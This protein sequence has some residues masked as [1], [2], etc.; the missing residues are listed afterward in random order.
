M[1]IYFSLLFPLFCQ[2]SDPRPY[3]LPRCS[4]CEEERSRQKAEQKWEGQESLSDCQRLRAQAA[5][6]DGL[7]RDAQRSPNEGEKT[8]EQPAVRGSPHQPG[9]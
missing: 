4:G 3:D 2:V 1:R 5:A 7:A 9:K 8:E 6:L